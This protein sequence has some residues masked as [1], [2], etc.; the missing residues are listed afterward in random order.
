MPEAQLDCLPGCH[1]PLRDG[2]EFALSHRVRRLTPCR[3]AVPKK[4]SL[5][6]TILSQEHAL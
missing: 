2:R 1:V 6:M 5:I 3:Q 4:I